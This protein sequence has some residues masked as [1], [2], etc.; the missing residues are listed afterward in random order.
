MT[1]PK[2]A[3]LVN[4]MSTLFHERLRVLLADCGDTAS[5]GGLDDEDVSKVLITGL[6]AEVVIGTLQIGFD[7][8]DFVRICLKARRE[9]IALMEK[10]RPGPTVTA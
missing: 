5:R 9:M 1:S 10:R 3:R 6:L 2:T 7:E 8:A 4:D